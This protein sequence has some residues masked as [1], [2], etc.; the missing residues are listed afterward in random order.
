[1]TQSLTL[2]VLEHLKDPHRV[3]VELEPKLTQDSKLICS[4]PNVAHGSV[5]LHLLGGS[6]QYE[7]MGILDRTHLR[8]FDLDGA[9]E[10]MENAGYRVENIE[11]VVCSIGGTRSPI[12]EELEDLVPL[13]AKLPEANTFQFVFEA[14][15]DHKPPGPRRQ[16]KQR[17]LS[18]VWKR[19][20][21]GVHS[22]L[23]L[24]AS[25]EPS[26]GPAPS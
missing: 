17:A 19:L 11:R 20:L 14:T 4:L 1:M 8:F 5:R 21:S 12:R 16:K 3:L 18:G 22:S 26:N 7:D 23:T 2:D 9:L 13:V 24:L 6:W 10:L 15:R 25:A